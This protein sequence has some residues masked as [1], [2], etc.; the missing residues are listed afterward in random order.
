MESNVGFNKQ[1]V[2]EK[3]V[4]DNPQH[5]D[6]ILKVVSQSVDKQLTI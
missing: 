3:L 6:E 4:A 1:Q 5:K 2:I